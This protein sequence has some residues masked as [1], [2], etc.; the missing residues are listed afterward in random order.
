MCCIEV[1]HSKQDCA[2]QEGDEGEDGIVGRGDGTD[3]AG[4]QGKANTAHDLRP[5]PHI[6]HP[7][8]SGQDMIP[9]RSS[10]VRDIR[11]QKPAFGS[12]KVPAVSVKITPSHVVL[13]FINTGS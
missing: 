6:S 9:K 7:S 8:N 13:P 2:G 10:S 5:F 4:G 12:R 1:G 3:S 11:T